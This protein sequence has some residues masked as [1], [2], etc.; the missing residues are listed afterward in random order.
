M[1]ALPLVLRVI[2]ASSK[3]VSRI[4][5]VSGSKDPL[6]IPS[7]LPPYD[8]GCEEQRLLE[9]PQKVVEFL[10]LP[11]ASVSCPTLTRSP[12]LHSVPCLATKETP[13]KAGLRS[14]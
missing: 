2:H 7:M 5:R 13:N 3:A 14:I 1:L 4:T 9:P 6:P 8:R 12:T 10:E 11:G